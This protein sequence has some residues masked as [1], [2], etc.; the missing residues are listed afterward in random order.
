MADPTW[1]AAPFPQLVLATG[2]SR[3]F[4]DGTLRTPMDKGPDKTR[5]LT[6]A[7]P[8]PVRCNIRLDASQKDD[9]ETFYK[10]TTASGSLRFTWVVPDTQ[11]AA[12][13]KFLGPPVVT[14]VARGGRWNAALTLEILP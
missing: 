4:S 8:E 7:N 9:L 10:S 11:V 3:T 13:L 5:R 1:P 12:K 2:Y 14:P 6:V